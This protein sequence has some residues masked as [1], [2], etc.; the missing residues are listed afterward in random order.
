[1]PESINSLYKGE[2]ITMKGPW[3]TVD[4]VVSSTADDTEVAAQPASDEYL[5]EGT[6]AIEPIVGT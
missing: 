5:G 2:L 6:L 1:V 4:D 3:R